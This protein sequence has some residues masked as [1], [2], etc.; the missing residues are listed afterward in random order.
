MKL[1]D[2]EFT[3]VNEQRRRIEGKIK[4]LILSAKLGKYQRFFDF[5]SEKSN[6]SANPFSLS[7]T[8]F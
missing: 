5:I 7:R 6:I 1:M 2:I 3:W 4:F 8:P